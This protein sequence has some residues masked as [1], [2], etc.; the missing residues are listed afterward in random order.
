MFIA[1]NHVPFIREQNALIYKYNVKHSTKK[2][3]ELLLQICLDVVHD[4]S[5]R[6]PTS[7][8]IVSCQL[9]NAVL[10]VQ[11][12]HAFH[13]K[14]FTLAIVCIQTA[15]KVNFSGGAVTPVVQIIMLTITQCF[16]KRAYL[17]VS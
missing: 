7:E 4:Q 12:I 16:A 15:H 17:L 1:L 13:Y 14:Q 6:A 9:P 8:Q 11:Y 10:L 3:I 2:M 5:P